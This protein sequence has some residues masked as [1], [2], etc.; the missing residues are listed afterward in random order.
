MS[1]EHDQLMTIAKDTPLLY[2]YTHK[3][4]LEIFDDLIWLSCCDKEIIDK[5]LWLIHRTRIRLRLYSDFVSAVTAVF[6]KRPT[7]IFTLSFAIN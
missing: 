1:A 7:P 2:V 6:E 5:T 3:Q 4:F